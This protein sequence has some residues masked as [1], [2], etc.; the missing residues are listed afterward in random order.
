M[1]DKNS[2][3]AKELLEKIKAEYFSKSK[4]I[5]DNYRAKG[6]KNEDEKW[7]LNHYNLEQSEISLQPK[8]SKSFVIKTSWDKKRYYIQDD[9]EYYLDENDKFELEL[10][11]QLIKTHF[12]DRLSAEEFAKI[13]KDKNFLEGVYTSNKIDIRFN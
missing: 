4:T 5:I 13:A 3:E 8:E 9:L 7:I 2:A 12:K 10:T 6:G 11:L 1:T